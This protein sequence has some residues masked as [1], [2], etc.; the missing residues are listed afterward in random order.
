MQRPP[1]VDFFIIAGPTASGKSH[2]AI[3]LAKV[4]D[5]EIINADSMQVYKDLSILTA[6]PQPHEEIVP[7]HLYGVL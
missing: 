5:G 7:H 1:N 6:R 4:W 3:E 2:L